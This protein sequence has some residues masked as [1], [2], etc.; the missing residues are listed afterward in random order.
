MPATVSSWSFS[1]TKPAWPSRA[2]RLP[3]A[4]DQEGG[5]AL[6]RIL[7]GEVAPVVL[8]DEPDRGEHHAHDADQ[9]QP[10]AHRE[11][12][13]GE[14]GGEG[15]PQRPPAVRAEESQLA[16]ALGDLALRV[17]LRARGQATA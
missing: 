4:S 3:G 8:E 1:P 17:V 15:H 13:R 7:V 16:G 9:D 11:A 5:A 2:P 14:S 12:D 6:E 10:P